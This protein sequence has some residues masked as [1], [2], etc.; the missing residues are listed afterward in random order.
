MLVMG[1]NVPF[2]FQPVPQL[3]AGLSPVAGGQGNVLLTHIG[4]SG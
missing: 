2:G 4:V 1:C 3:A